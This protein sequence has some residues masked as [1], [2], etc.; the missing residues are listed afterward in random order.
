MGGI[1]HTCSVEMS[2]RPKQISVR[3]GGIFI[4]ISVG[5]LT[6]QWEGIFIRWHTH[7]PLLTACAYLHVLDDVA[8][9]VGVEE[10]A[11]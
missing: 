8:L 2:R 3:G 5:L 11:S 10:K 4:P 1:T 7:K 6:V 9:V